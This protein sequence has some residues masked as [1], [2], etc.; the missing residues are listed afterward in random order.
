M[1]RRVVNVRQ[2]NSGGLARISPEDIR[3]LTGKIN[4]GNN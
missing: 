3:A 1:S 2:S 4:E